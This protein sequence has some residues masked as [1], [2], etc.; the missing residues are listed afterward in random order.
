MNRFSKNNITAERVVL[1][2]PRNRGRGRSFCSL[3]FPSELGPPWP[4][5]KRCDH[6]EPRH[7]ELASAAERLFGWVKSVKQCSRRSARAH[8]SRHL[9]EGVGGMNPNGI[10]IRPERRRPGRPWPAAPDCGAASA[11][12][13]EGSGGRGFWSEPTGSLP[14]R[15]DPS[16]SL[17][18]TPVGPLTGRSMLVGRS[19]SPGSVRRALRVPTLDRRSS[20]RSAIG[21][22]RPRVA[23]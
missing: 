7:R 20:L 21:R 19:P 11:R 17:G 6:Q 5:H 3:H 18:M 15:P 2:E 8:L 13:G 16:L 10:V 9:G 23:S 22:H 4:R 12:T 1:L 14:A